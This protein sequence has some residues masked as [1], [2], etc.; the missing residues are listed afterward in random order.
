MNSETGTP[1]A[2]PI[3]SPADPLVQP[4]AAV[5][6]A[7]GRLSPRLRQ[8]I[9]PALTVL[10]TVI[11][12]AGQIVE[13]LN[14]SA[15]LQMF[16]QPPL[17]KRWT[18]VVLV[19]Y[20]M[21]MSGVL[22]RT[23]TRSLAAV[24]DV[25]DVKRDAFD[26]YSVRL[27][28]TSPRVE[29][30]LFVVSALVTLLLFV[31]LGSDLLVDDP[32]PPHLS[33]KLPGDPLAALVILVAYMV[34]GW[35]FLRLIYIAGRSARILGRLSRETLRVNVFDTTDLIP[36]G[37]LALVIGLAPAG[38]IIIL[39]AGLGTPQGVVGWA[40]LVI[41]SIA[42]V[43]ALLLPLR[44]VHRQ[45]ADAKE[46]ALTGLN[47]R[48]AELYG[49]LSGP[50]PADASEATRLGSTTNA[51]IP[52]RKTIQEM[53]TWPFRNTVAFG[54][55]VLIASAPLIYTFLSELIRIGL[56]R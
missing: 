13:D 19:L 48:I 20:S 12:F 24:R 56:G 14:D 4:Q 22:M 36:F 47:L 5:D 45:M 3:T 31:I 49:T 26:S 43:V 30:G 37:N 6:G 28:H 54:R 53:T 25:V 29:T 7:R 2:A 32:V 52:L 8:M 38:A 34:V 10:A 42:T 46:N 21:V 35:T 9:Y 1:V 17:A 44:G 11:V 41:A 15:P 55:A 27:A 50:L 16:G 23:A 40:V 39:V 18:V 51:L 33:H